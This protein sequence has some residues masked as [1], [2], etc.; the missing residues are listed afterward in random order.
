LV[1][2]QAEKGELGLPTEFPLYERAQAGCP[3][4]LQTLMSRHGSLVQ[5]VVRRQYLGALPFDEAL[6][7]GRIGLWHAILGFDPGRGLAFSTYAW[8]CIMH[9]VW[10]AVKTAQCQQRLCECALLPSAV[11]E[12]P[13]EEVAEEIMRPSLAQA[14]Q[15]LLQRLPDSLWHIVVRYY[16]LDGY[17]PASYRQL[18]IQ[19]GLSHE[20][21]RQLHLQA[22]VWLRH[23]AH[24]Q[25]LR[26]LL[27]RHTVADYELADALAQQWLRKRGGRHER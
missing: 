27:G 7:A 15:E 24:S 8:P 10:Q 17:P 14:V 20:R 26:T 13:A 5:A 25:A 18:G 2:L 3:R 19:L 23:P 9:A 22:L 21:V 11:C 16:G 1:T 12:D 6:Q 4:S